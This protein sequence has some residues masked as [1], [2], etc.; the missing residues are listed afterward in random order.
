MSVL[1]DIDQLLQDAKDRSSF[2]KS[3]VVNMLLDL[4]TG[5]QEL[6]EQFARAEAR[7]IAATIQGEAA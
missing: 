7:L 4:R 6:T 1:S 5:A 2:S 3:E